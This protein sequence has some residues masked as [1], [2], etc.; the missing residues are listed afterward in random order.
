MLKHAEQIL[1]LLIVTLVVAFLSYAQQPASAPLAKPEALTN[2]DVLKM[3]EA[4]LGDDLI[5]SKIRSSPGDFDTSI[6]AI[7]KLKAAG[8]SDAVIHA[9]AEAS[10]T[11]KT[12]VKEA[13][14]T[15]GAS[16]LVK[17]DLKTPVRLM[18]DELLSSKTSKSGQ[19]FRLVA[20]EDVLVNGKIVVAKGSSATGRITLVEKGNINVYGRVEVTVDSV[21]AVDGH[22]IPLEGRLAESGIGKWGMGKD[23]KIEKGASINTVVAKETEVKM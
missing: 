1:S 17:V 15:G 19:T 14:L 13:S 7:L 12:V 5:V 4:K 16:G 3:V 2:S 18:V 22:N 23:A 10:P 6:D 11:A 21:R 8:A 20:A 9:M